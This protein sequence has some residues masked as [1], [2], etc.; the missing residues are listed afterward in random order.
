MLSPIQFISIFVLFPS[1]Y[2]TFIQISTQQ[3]IYESLPED[4]E[5]FLDFFFLF[6]FLFLAGDGDLSDSELSLD[7]DLVLLEED[8]DELEDD[9][10]DESLS[11][12][13]LKILLNNSSVA[14]Y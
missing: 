4:G 9:S 1:N 13:S 8:E 3:P 12:D 14:T 2:I 7:D 6:C 5:G 10:D 11:L